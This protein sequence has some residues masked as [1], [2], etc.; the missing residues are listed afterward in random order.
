MPILKYIPKKKTVIDRRTNDG[1]YYEAICDECGNEFYPKRNNARYCS[2]S[3]QQMA[4][5]NIKIAEEENDLNNISYF[6]D[7]IGNEFN[8]K[9]DLKSGLAY[10][11]K[12]FQIAQQIMLIV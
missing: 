12:S 4:W 1:G 2:K 3:C 10:H 6:C 7:L 9:N 5:R 11:L 8:R